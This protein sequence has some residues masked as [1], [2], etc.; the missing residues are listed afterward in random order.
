MN[1][2]YVTNASPRSGVG[3]YATCLKKALLAKQAASIHEYSLLDA[4]LLTDG[5][6][7]AVLALWP[8]ILGAKS[9]NWIRLGKKLPRYLGDEE[10]VH[11]TNQT[12]SFIK[13]KK[14]KV[15]TVHDIIELLEPQ[16]KKAYVVN[17]YLLSG[18]PEAD[19][20]I[21]V[22][23]YTKTALQE[24]YSLPDERITVIPNGIDPS[25]FYPI[26]GFA[27]STLYRDLLREL[28]I[29][30]EHVIVLYVGS[31][32]PRKNLGV[33]IRAFAQFKKHQPKAVFIKVGE[34]GILQGREAFL[35]DIK[36]LRLGESV[37]LTG[38]VTEERL[39]ALYNLADVLLFPSIFE[40]FGLP[41]LQAMA[42]GTPVVCSN[43]TS[44]PEVVGEAALQH[45]PEDI[46]GFADSLALI[47]QDMQKAEA[48]IASGRAQVKKFS[49]D[50]AA[51]M[52]SAVYTRTIHL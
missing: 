26:A 35:A 41:P 46:D 30:K 6:V 17:K 24:Y 16:D 25:V 32:H 44:L 23:T 22:S 45:D 42:A 15:V 49:W 39:N 33:A 34:A 5:D 12:L 10:L 27:D 21:S 13:T 11:A 52:T 1:I 9:V 47:T 51:E 2:A 4:S 40:G 36:H 8:G 28:D 20:I 14:P 29:T 31:D 37:R 3:N 18:I 48:L 19:H 7:R 43:A 38:G 50:K